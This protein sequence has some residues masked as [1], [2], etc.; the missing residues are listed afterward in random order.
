MT[1]ASLLLIRGPTNHA[2][3]IFLDV[4]VGVILTVIVLALVISIVRRRRAGARGRWW[5]GPY[6]DEKDPT[7]VPRHGDESGSR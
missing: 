1:A 3:E 4:S 2:E 7:I 5:Q 6:A